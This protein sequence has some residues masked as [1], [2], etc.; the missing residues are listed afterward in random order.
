MRP[1]RITEAGRRTVNASTY[2]QAQIV[3]AR[4]IASD[5]TGRV[6]TISGPNGITT[7]TNNGLTITYRSEGNAP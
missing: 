5:V 6:L 3:C 2:R 1:Y 7:A 4:R